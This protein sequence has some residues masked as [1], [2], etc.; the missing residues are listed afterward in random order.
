MARV[1]LTRA[2]SVCCES[3]WLGLAFP[4]NQLLEEPAWCVSTGVSDT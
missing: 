1:N 2:A 3:S 4:L